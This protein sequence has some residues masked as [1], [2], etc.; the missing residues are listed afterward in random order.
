M[1]SLNYP[2]FFALLACFLVVAS[3]KAQDVS[4]EYNQAMSEASEVADWDTDGDGMLDDHEFYLVNYH[5]WDTDHDSRISQEEWQ[6][7]VDSYISSMKADKL[8][9]FNDW[10]VDSN[11]SL[12]VN[13]FT[14]AMV[15][16]DPFE[17]ETSAPK[18]MDTT[19]TQQNNM[20]QQKDATQMKQEDATVMIWQLDNDDLVEKITY[21]D[22]EFVLDEDDN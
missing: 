22:W 5:I 17:F 3:L 18:Q 13:E 9:K 16:Q 4:D 7:G 15:E 1:K 12:S 11:D 2:H 6:S 14:L 10:D 21:G 20:A 19:Q 8:G